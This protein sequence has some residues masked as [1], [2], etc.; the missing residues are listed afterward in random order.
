MKNIY[1]LL[2]LFCVGVSS[3]VTAQSAKML[4]LD[5]AIDIALANNFDVKIQDQSTILAEGNITKAN[6]GYLPRV[7]AVAGGNYSNAFTEVDLRT[8]QPDPPMIN[9]SEWGVETTNMN[10]GLEGQYTLWDGGRRRYRYQ[11]LEGLSAIEKA[12]KQV[13]I[14]GLIKGVSELYFEIVK[15]QNQVLILEENVAVQTE[16]IQKLED[17]NSFGKVNKLAI[18]QAEANRNT[19]LSSIDNIQLVR[20]NLVADLKDLI[21]DVS[22]TEYTLIA[23]DALAPMLSVEE[24]STKLVANN[25]Q[26]KLANAGI[27]LA[28]IDQ[29]LA[30][31]ALKP[32]LNSFANFGYLY[33]QNDVQQL[34]QLQNVGITVG[35]TARYNLFDGGINK[36]NI[37]NA[38]IKKDIEVLKLNQ[39]SDNLVHQAKKELAT[40]RMIQAQLAR[41]TTNLGIFEANYDKV[42]ERYKI[43]QLPEI[44]LREAQLALTNAKI[45]IANLKA[46]YQQS[47]MRL[48]Q[49][50][51]NSF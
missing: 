2:T 4:T 12:K 20:A 35:L 9:L 3:S 36:R 19:D 43:G 37:E 7:D 8:F 21:G 40:Q 24:V 18:L 31:S 17:R 41:E 33:Q 29:L 16:Q 44:T 11:L 26:L 34:A 32:V 22:D 15:L 1:L 27:A 5:Q 25:P 50:M 42:N 13:V 39:L 23:A 49:L 48:K 30:K 10:L 38:Q 46:D 28:E 51:G 45:T 14:N 6:A 47:Q